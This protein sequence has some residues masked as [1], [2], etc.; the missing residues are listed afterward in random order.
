MIRNKIVLIFLLFLIRPGFSQQKD[1]SW[2]LP[3]NWVEEFIPFPLK[4]A[5]EI[6]YHGIEEI[7]FMPGWRGNDS[8]AGQRWSYTFSWYLDTL[9]YFNEERLQKD[10]T[11]YFDGLQKWVQK[12]SL[13]YIPMNVPPEIRIKR[14]GKNE[15]QKFSGTA[16]ILDIFFTNKPIR[17]NIKISLL[18]DPQAGKT[19]VLFELSPKPFS[20]P[21]WKQLD[22]HISEFKIKI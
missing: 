18:M 4:F 16:E 2:P 19:L 14:A 7:H 1:Y 6:N 17:L 12:N 11:V 3:D 10:L 15:S 22:Q 8:L 13:G 21:V 20:H 9:I 5:P